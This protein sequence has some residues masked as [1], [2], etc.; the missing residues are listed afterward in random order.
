MREYAQHG[1]GIPSGGT[2]G[3]SSEVIL[4]E[5]DKRSYAF[6]QASPNNSNLIYLSLNKGEPA[7]V[8]KGIVLQAGAAYEINA[9]NLYQGAVSAIADS[10]GQLYTIQS[11]R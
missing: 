3:T 5:D 6:I 8:G 7:E 1:G 2:L 9:V 10:A 11:G 4:D